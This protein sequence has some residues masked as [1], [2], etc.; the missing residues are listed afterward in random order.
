[1]TRPTAKGAVPVV[2]KSR[3]RM[4]HLELFRNLC[5]LGSLRKAADASSMTQPAATK[6]IQELETMF[7]VALFERD[8]RGMRPNAHGELIKR[9]FNVVMSDLGH[10]CDELTLYASG[11]A[12][13]VRL[14]IVPSLST[15]LL[16]RI[17]DDLLSEHPNVRLELTE[18]ATDR[19]MEG[20]L[21][22]DLDLIF[23]RVLENSPTLHLRVVEV[24]TESF[25]VVSASHHPLA[26]KVR[27]TW[28]DLSQ[29]KWILPAT[30]SPLREMAEQLFTGRGILRPVVSVSF[31]SF[32]QM[33]YVIA[34]GQLVGLLP[35]SIALQGEAQG[36]LARLFPT[37]RAKF[38][39]ISLICRQDIE[40]TPLV[41]QFENIVLQA[42][43]EL[44]YQ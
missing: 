39:P 29:A 12:G 14:G 33:R 9:H 10:M 24:Y 31:S 6:L 4:K 15:R 21:H 25:E 37:E 30:G 42:A 7:G 19:L 13:I 18:G 11:G 34:G 5:E 2:F 23:G 38:A 8:R 16:A 40:Q 44:G 32:H 36:D 27:V 20:L 22:N 3:L 26:H 1:M 17:T 35:T 28:E 43:R 41:H